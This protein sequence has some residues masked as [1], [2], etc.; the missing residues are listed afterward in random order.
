MAGCMEGQQIDAVEVAADGSEDFKAGVVAV[1]WMRWGERKLLK[2]R[3]GGI[4]SGVAGTA[5]GG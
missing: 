5:H 2:R 4:A 3:A 1:G